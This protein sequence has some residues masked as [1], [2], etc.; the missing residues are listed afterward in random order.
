VTSPMRSGWSRLTN[1]GSTTLI[2]ATATPSPAVP[3]HNAAAPPGAERTK[4]ATASRVRDP[5]STRSTPNRRA[6]AGATG[7]SAANATRGTLI[8][9]DAVELLSPRSARTSPSTGPTAVM[10][11][12]RF[13]PISSTPTSASPAR[14]TPSPVPLRRSPSSLVLTSPLV[15]GP[16]RPARRSVGSRL[17]CAG[18]SRSP[19]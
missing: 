19:R 14:L 8:S 11:A 16:G 7:E 10:P 2:N 12:R 18:Q 17:R 3:T 6:I 13:A 5:P 15:P 1:T 4:I 9:A